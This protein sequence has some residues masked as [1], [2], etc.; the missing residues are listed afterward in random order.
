MPH[1]RP[2]RTSIRSTSR[3]CNV[4]RGERRQH[5][6][7]YRVALIGIA[8]VVLSGALVAMHLSVMAQLVGGLAVLPLSLAA[9]LRLLPPPP[10]TDEGTDG[11]RHGQE[12]DS[13]GP[14]PRMSQRWSSYGTASSESSA[15]SSRTRRPSLVN[16]G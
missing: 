10:W 14:W 9:F 4:W 1:Q 16:S 2:P 11:W 7:A 15:P 12:S 13:G 8:A 5:P 3:L 6:V